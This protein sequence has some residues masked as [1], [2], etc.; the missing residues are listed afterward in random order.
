MITSIY[1]YKPTPQIYF[2]LFR[3]QGQIYI[4]CLEIRQSLAN[5][6]DIAAR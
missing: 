5:V 6:S 1:F 3:L 4:C 2:I